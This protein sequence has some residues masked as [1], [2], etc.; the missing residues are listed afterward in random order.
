MD[1]FNKEILLSVRLMTFNHEEFINQALKSIDMQ[2]TNFAFEVVIGDDFSTDT[3]LRKIKNFEFTNPKIRANILKREKGDDYHKKRLKKGRIYNFVDIVNNCKGKYIALLDG[4]DYWTDP[5][6]L[7]KQVD[8]LEG[9][10]EYAI[11]FHNVKI[12]NQEKG[13]FEKDTITRN[14]PET[15]TILDLARGNFIHTPSVV[16]RND[17]EIPNW[18]NETTIGDWTLYMIVVREQKIYKMDEEMAVYR[19]HD[20]GIWAKFPKFYRINKTLVSQKLVLR[21]L[22]LDIESKEL[23]KGQIDLYLKK[24]GVSICIPT[25]NG[26]K[27]LKETLQSI[28]SQTY[29]NI[30]VIVSDD[31][32]RDT[33]LAIVEAFKNEVDIPVHI[34]Q[35]TP[36]GIGSNWNNC[37]KN[38]NGKYIKFLFQDDVMETN[39]IE[40]MV[41]VLE[42]QTNVVLVASKRDFIIENSM[43]TTEIEDWIRV[44]GDL[45]SHIEL[46]QQDISI[47]DKSIFS[48]KTFY[49][50]PLNKIGEP[51]VVMFRKNVVDEVGFFREDLK[52]ILDYEYWYRILKKHDVAIINK[53]LVKFRLHAKQATHVNRNQSID[54]YKIYEQILYSQY[55]KLLHPE[56]RKRLYLKYHPYPLLKQRIKNKLK[57]LLK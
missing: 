12:Y 9:N 19:V 40:E 56:V 29:Q 6:K 11:C 32:S 18:F 2:E 36:N 39:C 51:S 14:V 57:R 22:K 31:A 37:M 21:K 24:C 50:S 13:H 55:L 3:T 27:Y 8:F 42:D 48:L 20:K 44:Y 43:K 17:F 34:F 46:P 23:L 54:D 7:Q 15:T 38:A 49:G 28:E 47:L 33:T 16:L 52:Q 26:A 1:T 5:L 25:Y 41:Q 30:E 4:D 53:P 10:P 35:H 45:Q